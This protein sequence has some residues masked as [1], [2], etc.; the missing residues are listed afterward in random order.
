MKFP[1]KTRIEYKGVFKVVECTYLTWN[2]SDGDYDYDYTYEWYLPNGRLLFQATNEHPCVYKNEYL[3]YKISEKYGAID[4]DGNIVINFVYDGIEI[5]GDSLI[6]SV[7][8][9]DNSTINTINLNNKIS[10]CG[11]LKITDHVIT[12]FIES[13]YNQIEVIGSWYIVRNGKLWGIFD[14]QG[15]LIISITNSQICIVGHTKNRNKSE[16]IE[17]LVDTDEKNYSNNF[18]YKTENHGIGIPGTFADTDLQNCIFILNNKNGVQFFCTKTGFL[19]NIMI[20]EVKY[21]I[22]PDVYLVRIGNIFCFYNLKEN[23]ITSGSFERVRILFYDN[24]KALVLQKG[25]WGLI[26]LLN[27]NKAFIDIPCEYNSLNFL[28]EIF[29]SPDFLLAQAINEKYGFINEKGYI[30]VPLMYDDIIPMRDSVFMVRIDDK[31]GFININKAQATAVKYSKE[32]INQINFIDGYTLIEDPVSKRFGILSQNYV[33]V[34]PTIYDEI[35]YSNSCY[36]YS[37]DTMIEDRDNLQHHN[38]KWETAVK[39]W[40][41]RRFDGT[42]IFDD[43]Y[44]CFFVINDQYVIAGKSTSSFTNEE[45]YF[46]N[47]N[48]MPWKAVKEGSIPNYVGV[49]DLY[50]TETGELICSG[51]S[52]FKPVVSG[53]EVHIGGNLKIEYGEYDDDLEY[54]PTYIVHVNY[55]YFLLNNDMNCIISGRRSHIFKKGILIEKKKGKWNIPEDALL[56]ENIHDYAFVKD[57]AFLIIKNKQTKM[58]KLIRLADCHNTEYYPHIMALDNSYYVTMVNNNAILRSFDSDIIN[59][60]DFIT[61]D[62]SHQLLCLKTIEDKF[63]LVELYNMDTHRT[64]C[65]SQKERIDALME[66]LVKKW[67]FNITNVANKRA[68]LLLRKFNA[69]FKEKIN[70]LFELSWDFDGIPIIYHYWFGSS[71]YEHFINAY[72]TELADEMEETQ[73]VPLYYNNYTWKDSIRDLC[74]GYEDAMQDYYAED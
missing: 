24:Y 25:K 62:I 5:Y 50:S 44:D 14:N 4:K 18:I 46:I 32:I 29:L 21:A 11:V 15:R 31:Y 1:D 64:S 38:I 55:K 40:G 74:D 43:I 57:S 67:C 2:R 7:F 16:Y 6:V 3:I 59:A 33:E 70:N 45:E 61:F 26:H 73:P 63:C 39:H 23:K 8:E 47:N 35:V 49:Y 22:S 66:S 13:K 56:M 10:T 17:Y 60:Y 51:I 34:V 20:D 54:T 41:C 28:E 65:I 52:G 30:S 58:I 69:E 27:E 72:V 48:F 9:N 19:Q 36:F 42:K 12:T 53:Y 71:L 37:Y 68:T